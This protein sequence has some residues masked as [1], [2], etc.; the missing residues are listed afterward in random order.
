[1][2]I[3]SR[4]KKNFYVGVLCILTIWIVFFDPNDLIS[5]IDN[6]LSYRKLEDTKMYYEQKIIQIE[7]DLK[8]LRTNPKELEKFAREMYLMKKE[9]EDVYLIEVIEETEKL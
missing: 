9:N 1:M 3:I 5:L 4:I 7:N 8:S 6:Y 2:N